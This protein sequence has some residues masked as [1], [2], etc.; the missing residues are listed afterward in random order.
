MP[1]KDPSIMKTLCMVIHMRHDQNHEDMDTC[2]ILKFAELCSKYGCRVIARPS[3]SQW[4]MQELKAVD[5]HADLAR[6]FIAASFFKEILSS[7]CVGRELLM[8][9]KTAITNN[10]TLTRPTRKGLGVSMGL[11]GEIQIFLYVMSARD[12][13]H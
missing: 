11:L 10:K 12:T 7:S 4:I 13:D 6:L 9:S 8:H 1:D 5:G 3:V 2:E